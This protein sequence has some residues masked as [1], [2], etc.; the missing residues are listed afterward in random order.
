MVV[1]TLVL[2]F[3]FLPYTLILLLGYKL[4]RFSGK[5]YFRWLN[6]I[7]PLLESYYAPYTVQT[8]YWTG[9][10]LLLRCFLYILFSTYSL[11]GSNKSLLAIILTFTAILALQ[12]VLSL[13]FNHHLYKSFYNSILE[14]AVYINLIVVSASI[15]AGI[16]P[17]ALVYSLV[18][19]VF[20]TM[21]GITAYHFHILYTAKLQLWLQFEAKIV[22]LR[23]KF[24]PKQK[25][26][27]APPVDAVIK[28]TSSQDPHKLVTH[29]EIDLREPLLL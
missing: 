14:I 18:G 16:N 21:L 1:T 29:S 3:F 8:R 4:Y 24:Y 6:R 25:A 17:A 26:G 5:K 7:K 9:L 27:E 11:T 22:A 20:A 23:G 12:L 13:R 19:L 2:V 15:L 10:L 28:Q